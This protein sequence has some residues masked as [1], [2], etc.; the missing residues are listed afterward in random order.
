MG[1]RQP[2]DL[3]GEKKDDKV[4]LIFNFIRLNLIF[5]VNI[6]FKTKKEKKK[7]YEPPVPTRIGK[8]KKRTKGP[9][10]VDKYS[11]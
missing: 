1:N 6:L 9:E 7:K 11:L 5:I 8:K 4:C 3:G 10:A 2:R